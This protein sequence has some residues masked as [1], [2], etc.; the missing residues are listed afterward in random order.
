M[1]K[2]ADVIGNAVR[3]A[4]I[5]TGEAE[6]EYE[7]CEGE[8]R[9]AAE[10]GRGGGCARRNSDWLMDNKDA[11]TALLHQDRSDRRGDHA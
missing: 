10:L 7:V 1:P 11:H 4:E 6:D 3:V 5:A 8:N 9:A 2:G